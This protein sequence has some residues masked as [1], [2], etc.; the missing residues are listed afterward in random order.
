MSFILSIL[1]A[2]FPFFFKDSP[3]EIKTIS[4]SEMQSFLVQ[5]ENSK[6]IK[7][8]DTVYKR[9]HDW[10]GPS[11]LGYM[12]SDSVLSDDG[13]YS[14]QTF[15][16]GYVKSNFAV[17]NQKDGD[18][19]QITILKDKW[20]SII[21]TQDGGDGIQWFVG[22]DDR[23]LGWLLFSSDVS[24]EWKSIVAYLNKTK[25]DSETP[26]KYNPALTRYKRLELEIPFLFN[27]INKEYKK[28]DI[29]VSEHYNGSTIETSDF[30]ERF[31]MAKNFGFIRWERWANKNI[32]T[33]NISSD[34][35][36]F[37]KC[38]KF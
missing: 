8:S 35:S 31:F 9:R 22:R 28:L 15:D 2:I 21:S 23:D 29:I 36:D 16:F 33:A 12:A 38:R 11:N 25:T 30:V 18:G 34:L 14:I 26:E 1:K 19:G 17:F 7:Q 5:S 37:F 6:E 4:P 3:P 24:T 27:G 32:A 13:R 10:G 20:A